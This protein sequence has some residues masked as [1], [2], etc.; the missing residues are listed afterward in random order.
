MLAAATTTSHRGRASTAPPSCSRSSR[1]VLSSSGH[2]A[3]IVN[4]PEPK[5]RCWTNDALPPTPETWLAD[6]VSHKESWWEDW[7][8]WIGSE[9]GKSGTHPPSAATSSRC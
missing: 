5:A 7:A 8:R 9:R 6:A 3:G 2:I 4:P 1:F